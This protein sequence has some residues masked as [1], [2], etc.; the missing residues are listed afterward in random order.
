MYVQFILHDLTGAPVKY[1]FVNNLHDHIDKRE[2]GRRGLL[3]LESSSYFSRVA[4]VHY[5]L[6]DIQKSTYT[7]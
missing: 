1:T 2:G 3:A 6:Y 7:T 5:A 4:L